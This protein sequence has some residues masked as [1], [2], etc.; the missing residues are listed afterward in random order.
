L[1]LL[2]SILYC[3]FTHCFAASG[4]IFEKDAEDQDITVVTHIL[5]MDVKQTVPDWMLHHHAKQNVQTYVNTQRLMETLAK[6]PM[7]KLIMSQ[8]DS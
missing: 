5:Q 6:G 2:F 4:F 7:G 3:L 1:S 8:R